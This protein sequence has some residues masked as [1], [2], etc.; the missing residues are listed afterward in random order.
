MKCSGASSVSFHDFVH[1]VKQIGCSY[2]VS[3]VGGKTKEINLSA[4]KFLSLTLKISL[5]A[6][7]S[8]GVDPQLLFQ[9]SPN[10][11]I[12]EISND[13]KLEIFLD[14]HS[15]VIPQLYLLKN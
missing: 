1:H 3:L 8:F 13:M 15:V 2:P 12:Y 9:V 11:E 10:F 7:D 14:L 4:R 5:D 6:N